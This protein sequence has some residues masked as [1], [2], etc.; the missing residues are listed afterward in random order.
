MKQKK[1]EKR[2]KAK[3]AKRLKRSIESAPTASTSKQLMSGEEQLE[4]EVVEFIKYSNS[5]S[6]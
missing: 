2:E 3:A 6:R 5:C 4:E 1:K